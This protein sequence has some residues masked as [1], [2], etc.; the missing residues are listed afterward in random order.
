MEQASPH[1]TAL[2]NILTRIRETKFA[3]EEG[4]W[5]D[6]QILYELHNCINAIQ[7][8]LYDANLPYD[9]L[10]AP[11]PQEEVEAELGNVEQALSELRILQLYPGISLGLSA[12]EAFCLLS[13]LQLALTHPYMSDDGPLASLGKTIARSIEETVVNTPHLQR[14]AESVWDPAFDIRLE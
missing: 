12:T 7:V 4:N 10:P 1:E 14:L 13:I 2:L 9:N 3:I 11:R 5:T 6:R 8:I